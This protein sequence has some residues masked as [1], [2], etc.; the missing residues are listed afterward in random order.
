LK[1]LNTAE[2]G[3]GAVPEDAWFDA[4]LVLSIWV[5]IAAVCGLY[6]LGLFRTDHDHNEVKIGPGRLLLGSGFIG[7]ALFF[8]PALFGNPPK[9]PLWDMVVGILPADVA[10]L[11]RSVASSAEASA[12]EI[13]ARSTDPA[14]AE[15][16]E[17]RVH[18]VV[19]GLSYD[20]ALE[21]A[22]AA[23]KPILIDFTGVNCTN[24]RTMEQTVLNRKEIA[25]LLSQFVTV[26]LYTDYVP[27]ASLTQEQRET[28]AEKNQLLQL[29]LTK[30]A[31]NPFY[32]V[33]TPDGRLVKAIGG[34]RKPPIFSE[35]L[36]D[37]LAKNQDWSKIAQATPAP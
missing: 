23:N 10:D 36:N 8:A 31:T 24:C 4:P 29:D 28:L 20:A 13:K 17:K 35:F 6:L 33:L 15:R 27:I 3:F 21:E 14:V 7:L 32:V 9:S 12:G 19:W 2:I 26:Q 5:G 34:Y 25:G 22:K 37:A 18:G 30:E 11:D 16:E 1:F